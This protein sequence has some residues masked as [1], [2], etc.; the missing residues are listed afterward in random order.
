MTQKENNSVPR[1]QEY[2]RLTPAVYK[3]LENAMVPPVV[4]NS[5]TAHMA[6]YQLGVQAV[7]KALREGFIV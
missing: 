2:A 7:L 5:T 3:S 1:I 4:N 6:G